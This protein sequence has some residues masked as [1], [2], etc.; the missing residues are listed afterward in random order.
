MALND[1][2]F[3]KQDGSIGG[4]LPNEDHISALVFLYSYD[5]T[6]PTIDYEIGEYTGIKDAESK[7]IIKETY[8]FEHYHISEF[9]RIN[10]NARLFVG[11]EIAEDASYT[12]AILKTLQNLA[13]GNIRQFGILD[14]EAFL[15]SRIASINSVLLELEEEHKP[16]IAV[17]GADMSNANILS[18]PDLRER[19]DHKVS[20]L[21]S[22]GEDANDYGLDVKLPKVPAIGNLL[23]IISKAAIHENIG[24]I[25]KFRADGNGFLENIR[26]CTGQK[27]SEVAESTLQA[28]NN[29]GYIFHRYHI[30]IAGTY[31]NDSH[32]ATAITSDYCYL[33]RNRTIDKAIRG[34]RQY[35][36]P[37]LNSPIDLDA[38]TG[39][40]SIPL[41]KS[42][43]NLAG[44]ALE[45]MQKDGELSGFK[46]SIDPNQD[47]LTTSNLLVTVQLVIKGVAR[48][49]TV[50][51]AFAK[52]VN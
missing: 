43:E 32:T 36:L 52:S 24:W 31:Y 17:Y 27:Y 51:V 25:E 47:I 50:S 34:M 13:N 5:T 46:V 37:K 1:V 26:F 49:I 11:Y 35:L 23:G 8:S 28:L 48:Q 38:Q 20:V 44:K 33:E 6:P 40:L 21:L 10:P 19:T 14:K 3:L 30:G 42:F 16:A 45:Q 41:I 22:N 18:L 2:I 39:R 15:A 29:K 4:N 7:G 9:F 12:F